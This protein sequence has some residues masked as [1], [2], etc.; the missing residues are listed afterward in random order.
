MTSSDTFTGAGAL[1]DDT[2][3]WMCLD[4]PVPLTVRGLEQSPGEHTISDIT[5]ATDDVTTH[6]VALVQEVERV[7]WQLNNN[8][9]LK[10][11]MKIH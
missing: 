4:T 1:V 2:D 7:V 9:G 10:S 11:T 3:C 6:C 5:P 8:K